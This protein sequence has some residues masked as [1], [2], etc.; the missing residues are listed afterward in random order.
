MVGEGAAMLVPRLMAARGI[1]PDPAE[2]LARFLAL[3]DERLLVH[4]RP[5]AGIPEALDD[6]AAVGAAGGPHQQAGGGHGTHPGRPPAAPEIRVGHRR[7][8]ADRAQAGSC[9]PA[10]ADAPRGGR[11]AVDGDGRRF[12]GR[13]ADGPQRRHARVPDA[14]RLRVRRLVRR[15]RSEATSCS[16]TRPSELPSALRPLVAVGARPRVSA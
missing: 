6:V 7:G 12:G 8:H 9:R 15:R 5:Y 3:Y 4:T 1:H 11:C 16:W 2:A 13:P 14:L 10:L